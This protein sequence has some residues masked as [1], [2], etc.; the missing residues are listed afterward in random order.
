MS[1]YVVGGDVPGIYHDSEAIDHE[2]RVRQF[3]SLGAAQLYIDYR[4]GHRGSVPIERVYIAAQSFGDSDYFV[5]CT[6]FGV[7]FG[8]NNPNNIAAAIDEVDNVQTSFPSLTRAY[9]WGVLYCL[10]TI[11]ERL[12]FKRA[13]GKTVVYVPST[14]LVDIV[15]NKVWKWNVS[16]IGYR[17]L[18]GEVSAILTNVN[19]QYSRLGWG[20]LEFKHIPQNQGHQVV[21]VVERMAHSGAAR[22]GLYEVR[23]Q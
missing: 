5:P 2:A 16:A 22:M 11:H 8:I 20:S 17:D 23:Y 6:G 12:I 19:S 15:T 10:K 1:F 9:L 7:Y 18:L 4:S 13:R 21:E 3:S 14:E